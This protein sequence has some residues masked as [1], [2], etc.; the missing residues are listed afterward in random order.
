MVVPKAVAALSAL[1]IAAITQVAHATIR[2]KPSILDLVASADE[3]ELVPVHIIASVTF[4]VSCSRGLGVELHKVSLGVIRVLLLLLGDLLLSLLVLLDLELLG[5]LLGLLALLVEVEV[6]LENWV[7]GSRIGG[8]EEVGTLDLLLL[9]LLAFI[10]ET[11]EIDLFSLFLLRFSVLKVAKKIFAFG[12]A[13]Q[14]VISGRE[15]VDWLGLVFLFGLHG[16][17]SLPFDF[18]V[19]LGMI[20]SSFGLFFDKGWGSNYALFAVCYELFDRSWRLLRGIELL[21]VFLVDKFSNLRHRVV[22]GG[23][24]EPVGQFGLVEVVGDFVTSVG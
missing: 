17:G 1:I 23:L 3:V 11:F 19:V 12:L 20:M 4:A 9:L 21:D 7:G 15:K 18:M 8:S 22:V 16:Q 24:S 10:L 5:L 6:E 2:V 14:K 13:C